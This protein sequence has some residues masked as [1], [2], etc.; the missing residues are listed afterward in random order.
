MAGKSVIDFADPAPT[1]NRRRL[2]DLPDRVVGGDP[3]HVTELHHESADGVLSAGTWTSTPGKWHAF[4]GREEFCYI[5]S[6]HVELIDE[7]GN[8]QA[9]KAGDSFLIPETF[10]GYWN[11]IETTTKRF[12]IRTL[13]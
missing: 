1:V 13:K 4:T 5:V 11:V 3:H 7:A 8:A 2:A 6:G 12:V 9:F 10:R